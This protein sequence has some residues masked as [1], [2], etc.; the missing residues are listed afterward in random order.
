MYLT[1][2]V[3]ILTPISSL[4]W[5]PHGT[6]AYLHVHAYDSPWYKNAQ[7]YLWSE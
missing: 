4:E 6:V 1:Y 5:K 7:K 2:Y 3:G